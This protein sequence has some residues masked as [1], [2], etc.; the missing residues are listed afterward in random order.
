MFFKFV[1]GTTLVKCKQTICKFNENGICNRQVLVM[2]N[3]KC[4]NEKQS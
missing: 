1:K 3:L 2:G 4:M